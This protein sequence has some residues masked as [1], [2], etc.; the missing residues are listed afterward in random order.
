M[1]LPLGQALLRP[2]VSSDGRYIALITPTS[3][4]QVIQ[5]VDTLEVKV[6]FDGSPPKV[7]ASFLSH[8][9]VLKW[10]PLS[11]TADERSCP[12]WLLLSD[13]LRLLVFNTERLLELAQDHGSSSPAYIAADYDFG[14]HSG[15]LSFAD[16]LFDTKH[17][18]V[19]FES[20]GIA[21][22]LST[23]RA[24][25]DDIANVKFTGQRGLTRSANHR[26]VSLLTRSKGQDQL[27]LL[28]LQEGE[29]RPQ[30]S[31]NLPTTDAQSAHFSPGLDPVL[32]VV[33]S[34]SYGVR[35]NFFSAMGHPLEALNM[36]GQ[37][38]TSSELDGVG[39][40]QLRWARSMDNSILVVADGKKQIL[41]REQNHQK[42]WVREIGILQHPPTIDGSMSLVWQQTGDG[43]FVLQKAAFD[44]VQAAAS[45]TDV[46]L[47]ETN[48]DQTF[49]ASTVQDNPN[50]C[51]VWQPN[52][53]DPHTIVTF[54]DHVKFLLWHPTEPNVLVV[55]TSSKD[56]MVYCWHTESRPPKRCA[57]PMTDTGSNK[58]EAKW[59]EP[60]VDGRH[61][62]VM[63]SNKAI[64]YGLLRHENGQVIF[65]SLPDQTAVHLL[66]ESDASA[67]ATPSKPAK[68]KSQV[69]PNSELW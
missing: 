57:I 54:T 5:V 49:L 23:T 67:L 22:I 45:T 35:V 6:L 14:E 61:P 52:H 43:E 66:D 42:L 48:C 40:S 10:S 1:S 47:L 46:I 69:T 39:V 9:T 7:A 62:F 55:T 3:A 15:K 25:R 64:G 34:P 27:L 58:Y 18:L 28:G 32:T 2:A 11:S 31:F 60:A 13:G 30:A 16:F 17:V 29:V 4:L 12:P 36:S 24:Q 37:F 19:M 33:D 51:W 56:P 68:V 38:G 65:D 8:L 63:T 50:T 26:T 41:V 20:S 53:P 44:A 21:S 59:V